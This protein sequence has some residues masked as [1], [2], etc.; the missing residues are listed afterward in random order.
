MVT[1]LLCYVR[2]LSMD[3]DQS[4]RRKLVINCLKYVVSDSSF[5]YIMTSAAT[6]PTTQKFFGDNNYFGLQKENVI[7]F[8]QHTLPCLTFEGK[9]I[10]EDK[11]KVAKAPDG[12]GGL[13][14]A[15][16]TSKIVE[17]LEKRGIQYVHV[18]C[19]DNILVKLADPIF[20]G[21]CLSKRATCAAK[22]SSHIIS[23]FIN[24]QTAII[25]IFLS[26]LLTVV[27]KR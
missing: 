26:M 5:R 25:L 22:V 7:F 1:L 19:V 8:E 16:K 9:I 15:L 24:K 4:D 2:N 10:L 6:R 20:I 21:Y 14:K 3:S 11:A 23:C 12:N 18:Y 17:D 13:Y 27:Y